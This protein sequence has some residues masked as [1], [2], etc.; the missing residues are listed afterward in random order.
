MSKAIIFDI[1]FDKTEISIYEEQTNHIVNCKKYSFNDM[2]SIKSIFK[3]INE[4]TLVS[5]DKVKVPLP[6]LNTVVPGCTIMVTKDSYTIFY[7]NQT[8]QLKF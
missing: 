7:N 2:E 4:F 8:A 6:T 3:N 1:I 5:D